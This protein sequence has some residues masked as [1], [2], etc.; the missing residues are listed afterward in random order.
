MALRESFRDR[1]GVHLPGSAHWSKK[2]TVRAKV[3]M[4]FDADDRLAIVG[5]WLTLRY[6]SEGVVRNVRLLGEREAYD[7]VSEPAEDG[8]GDEFEDELENA[9]E[10]GECPAGCKCNETMPHSTVK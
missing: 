10:A 7:T 5:R 8:H 4:E 1:F 6:E 2:V 9:D 3:E